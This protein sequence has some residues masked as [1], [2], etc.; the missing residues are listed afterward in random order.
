MALA[1]YNIKS[2]KGIYTDM[3]AIRK[4]EDLDGL[5]FKRVYEYNSGAS[6]SD[7]T[8]EYDTINKKLYKW[9]NGIRQEETIDENTIY[10]VKEV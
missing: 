10:I 9:S 8:L 5:M 1:K 2:G 3:N 6:Y 7:G 4:D